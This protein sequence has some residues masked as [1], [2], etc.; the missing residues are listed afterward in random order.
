MSR[1]RLS[2]C[3]FT[4]NDGVLADDLL[5]D[6]GRWTV[7]PDEIL[8]VDDGSDP[9]YA[10]A[11]LPQQGRIV[12]QPRN[13][14]ITRAK[15]T[16]VS[17]AT[18]EV[19][20]AVDC[21]VR[22]TPGWLAACLPHALRSEV[23]L[24]SGPVVHAAGDDCVS[25]Y[26]RAF[27]D[28][29]NLG[30]TGAVDFIP[31]NAWLL[32]R[33]VWEAVGGL[34]GFDQDVCEDRCLCGRVRRAGYQLFIEPE[35]RAL[36]VRKLSRVAALRRFWKWCH[37]AF[38]AEPVAEASL[39]GLVCSSFVMPMSERI[40]DAVGWGTLEFLYLEVAYLSHVALD[41]CAF[42]RK[43]WGYGETPD[44]AWWA[45][46]RQ[47]FAGQRRLLA[48]LTADL[49]AMG[50]GVPRPRPLAANPFAD[51]FAVLES[52]RPSGVFTWLDSQGVARLLAEEADGQRHFSAYA[53][54]SLDEP[55][56]VRP[57]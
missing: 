49:A 43:H 37:A 24:V 25:R 34:D 15:H 1:P 11:R 10:P 51:A 6:L 48:L 56:L 21:D 57:A 33:D 50:H 36:Q 5:A 22:L 2:L 20:L 14:G 41:L 46:L 32:R 39:P 30:A 3:T 26:L 16:G 23:G 54:A 40:A 17:A 7:Q 55:G 35:A 44:Q 8:V 13:T 47:F 18:G 12:R 38:K 19:I 42:G 31:G 45:G 53:T 28:N 52:L 9:P 4:Y 27:G 29:H